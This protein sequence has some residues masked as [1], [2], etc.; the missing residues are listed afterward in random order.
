M[1]LRAKWQMHKADYSTYHAKVEK[2]WGFIS[3]SP[4]RIHGVVL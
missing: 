1:V 3:M 2:M 4:I